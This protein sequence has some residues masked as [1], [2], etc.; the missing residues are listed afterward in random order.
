MIMNAREIARSAAQGSYGYQEHHPGTAHAPEHD[1]LFK[2]N[3][4]GYSGAGKSCL[5]L[6]YADDIYTESHIVTSG[7]ESKAKMT[8]MAGRAIKLQIRDAPSE[9]RFRDYAKAYQK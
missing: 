8:Q 5:L 4:M 9:E 1:Y 6:R 2:I 7:L 3:L